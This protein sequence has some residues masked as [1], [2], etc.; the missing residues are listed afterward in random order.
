MVGY[1]KEMRA[2]THGS[3]VNL[4]CLSICFSFLSLVLFV[5]NNNAVLLYGS[6]INGFL[7]L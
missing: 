5:K 1:V 7:T 4:G 6:V 2:R 3:L